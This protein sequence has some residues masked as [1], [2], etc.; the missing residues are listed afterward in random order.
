MP[1]KKVQK[2]AAQAAMTRKQ[3]SRW[4][5]EKRQE[6]LALAFVV[7]VVV[8]I[9]GVLGTGFFQESVAKPNAAFAKVNG[10]SLTTTQW[11]KTMVLESK[12]IQAEINYWQNQATS[13]SSDPDTQAYLAS[14]VEQQ[15]QQLT[16]SQ[17]QLI[18][19][20]PDELM[21]TELIRQEC[22]RR[23][24]TVSKADGDAA[25]AA[26]LA[27]SPQPVATD[28]LVPTP[29]PYPADAWLQSYQEILKGLSMT[30]AEY[31]LLALEPQIRRDRLQVV[32]SQTVATSGEQI[33]LSHI[34]TD[35]AEAAQDI[36][37]RLRAG[38]DFATLA[39]T[40]SADTATAEIGGDLGWYPRD[41]LIQEFN[42]SVEDAAW[43][44]SAGEVVSKA[45]V[46]IGSY[47]I[48][49]VTEKAADRAYAD[50]KRAILQE[51]ALNKWLDAQLIS[52][53]IE[54]Y[55]DSEKLMWVQEQV[56]KLL[57]AKK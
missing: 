9:V 54:R 26:L 39:A 38:E 1:K 51:N 11:A 50:D 31:R 6:R 45:V 40:L 7:A 2:P 30:D 12:N 41:T 25:L 52:P 18:W 43:G 46:A 57:T 37:D 35:S 28:T 22:E 36:L 48:L 44:L 53:A 15:V 8:L 32:F 10:V 4:Q 5:K 16:Q 19:N 3:L 14:L 47:E 55:L 21:A 24:I 34:V 17:Q 13:L 27:P 29:T 23:G 33:R 49:K 56:N 20:V 42:Q